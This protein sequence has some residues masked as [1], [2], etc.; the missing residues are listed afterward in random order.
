MS[1][2][3]AALA[4][5][6]P[7]AIGGYELLGRIGEGGFGTVYLARGSDGLVAVKALRVDRAEDPMRLVGLESEVRVLAGAPVE[8]VAR[9]LASDLACDRPYLVL[10]YLACPTLRDSV[11]ATG[12]LE[13]PALRDLALQLALTVSMLHDAD[14]VHRD[15][16][17]RN[18]MLAERPRLID[19]GN[20]DFGTQVRDIPSG[21]MFGSPK[22][23]ANEQVMGLPVGMWTDV[24]AWGLCVA[25]AA[26]GEP[27]FQAQ[28]VPAMVLRVVTKEPDLPPSVPPVLAEVVCASLEKRGED[29]PTIDEVVERLS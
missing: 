11:D 27:P 26:T 21:A 15:I 5:H 9:L 7:A 18:V 19:F 10:E 20:A 25:F 23:M 2:A 16:K 6:D 4:D 3:V 29:R 28:S 22:W 12:P 17:P 8:A 1:P 14:V 13:G 24:H